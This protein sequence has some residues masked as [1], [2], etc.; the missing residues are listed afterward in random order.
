[1][2]SRIVFIFRFAIALGFIGMALAVYWFRQD[3]GLSNFQTYIFSVLLF[4][5]GLFRVY[6]AYR[7]AE[8]VIPNNDE[9]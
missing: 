6:R 5:Y 2:R 3:T 7:A 4:I 8:D 9:L 1:M